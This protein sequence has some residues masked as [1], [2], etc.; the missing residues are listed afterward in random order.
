MISPVGGEKLSS[1]Y[2]R[3]RGLDPHSSNEYR[4]APR[5]PPIEHVQQRNPFPPIELRVCSQGRLDRN[6]AAEDST[7]VIFSVS[8]EIQKRIITAPRSRG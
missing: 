4:L 8:A 5:L 6:P 1:A 2:P 3:N 7:S